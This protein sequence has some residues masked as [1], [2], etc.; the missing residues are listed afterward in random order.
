V[1]SRKNNSFTFRNAI[2]QNIPFIIYILIAISWTL[3][4][5]ST[6]VNYSAGVRSSRNGGLIVFALLMTFTFGK[7]G[8]RVILARLTMSPFPWFNVG[9]FGPLIG[10]AILV[11]LPFFG[12]YICYVD[13]L[14]GQIPS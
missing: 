11:N 2:M 14:W 8:P 4:P 13:W 12:M 10:G 3:S 1:A 6:I 7:L 9:A 5:Y